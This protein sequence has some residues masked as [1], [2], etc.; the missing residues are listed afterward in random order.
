MTA[1]ILFP[2]VACAALTACA[3]GTTWPTVQVTSAPAPSY[4]VDTEAPIGIEAA[5]QVFYEGRPTYYYQDHWYYRDGQQWRYYRDEPSGLAEHR[6]RFQ[7]QPY[8]EGTLPGAIE[9][10]PQVVY[11]GRPTYYYQNRWYYRDGQKWRY[12]RSEP[13]NLAEHRR[14]FQAQPP[15]PQHYQEGPGHHEQYPQDHRH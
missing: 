8:Y 3:A 1:R 2:I 15:P 5:P 14:R 4:Y 6:V 10:A 7:E 13:N 12:Y 9:V 11:E